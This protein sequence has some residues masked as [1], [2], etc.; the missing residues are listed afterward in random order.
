MRILSELHKKK[1]WNL[2]KMTSPFAWEPGIVD[3]V[4]H[5]KFAMIVPQV[6]SHSLNQQVVTGKEGE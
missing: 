5:D 1:L 2:A 6:Q 3:R 4:A